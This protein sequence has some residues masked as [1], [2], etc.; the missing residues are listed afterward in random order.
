MRD[1]RR[2]APKWRNSWSWLAGSTKNGKEHEARCGESRQT[3]SG[4]FPPP[5]GSQTGLPYGGA[6]RKQDGRGGEERPYPCCGQG[7]RFSR[8]GGPRDPRL[9]RR[10]G[11]EAEEIPFPGPRRNFDVG[12]GNALP[13]SEYGARRTPNRID[14]GWRRRRLSPKHDKMDVVQARTRPVS[15]DGAGGN[16]LGGDSRIVRFPAGRPGQSCVAVVGTFPAHGTGSPG[17]IASI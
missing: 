1:G 11:E 4:P 3:P 12:R 2:R 13:D 5:L 10:T 7:S 17:K 8:L 6:P 16:F 9:A 14:P 15:T